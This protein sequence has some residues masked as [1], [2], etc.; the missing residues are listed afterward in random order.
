MEHRKASPWGAFFVFWGALFAVPAAPAESP[1][2]ADRIDEWAWTDHVYDGDTLRLDDGRRL[3]LLGIDTPELRYD[4]RASDPFARKAQKTLQGIARTGARI[5]L[6]YDKQ[7]YDRYGRTLAHVFGENGQNIQALLL[8]Q[9]LAASLLI[10]P[11]DWQQECYLTVEQEAYR[12]KRGIWSHPRYRSVPA[13]DMKPGMEGYYV[14]TGRV[15]GVSAGDGGR[16]L[17]LTPY[18][19]VRI[20][21]RSREAFASLDLPS[22]LNRQITVRGRVYARGDRRLLLLLYHPAALELVDD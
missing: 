16:W 14:V 18:V 11:N 9:G 6:R 10:P 13:E 2:P 22:L 19:A 15:R 20:P 8:E 1:C 3:R 21:A 4:G 17:D 7:R 5:G 12:A